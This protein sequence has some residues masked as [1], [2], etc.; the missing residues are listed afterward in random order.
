MFVLN[1]LLCQSSSDK[2]TF[3]DSLSTFTPGASGCRQMEMVRVSDEA[4]VRMAAQSGDEVSKRRLADLLLIGINKNGQHISA[5]GSDYRTAPTRPVV[6]QQPDT[7]NSDM[8]TSP[9]LISLS[10]AHSATRYIRY[11]TPKFRKKI[12]K[13]N[14]VYKISNYTT[15]K[16]RSRCR[17]LRNGSLDNPLNICQI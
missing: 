5:I 2:V 11:F 4:A 6:R 12:F 13:Q 3:F 1:R 15:I 7:S 9:F 17:R 14:E 16:M 8:V 10:F